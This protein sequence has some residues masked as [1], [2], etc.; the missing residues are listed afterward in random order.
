MIVSTKLTNNRSTKMQQ[1]FAAITLLFTCFS[2]F[3]D[4]ACGS[5]ISN[6][7][8][9]AQR[10]DNEWPL[11]PAHDRKTRFVQ[12]IAD[13]LVHTTQSRMHSR[14]FNWPRRAWKLLLVRDLSVNA[15]SIGDGRIYLTDGTFDFVKT[16]AEL[17]AI[18]AHE[19]AHQLIGH[20]CQDQGSYTEYRIGSLVQVLDNNK[21]MEADAL[22][23]E[24]LQK[25]KFPA[26]AMFDI[27]KRLPIARQN[28]SHKRVRIKA[29]EQQLQG[30]KRPPFSS[31]SEFIKI[32]SQVGS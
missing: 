17:A 22:A 7:R 21:E 15:Y 12:K 3:V 30:I 8:R 24:I 11:R 19:L 28:N 29:L 23:V 13:S 20:F 16:E 5:E 14:Y 10:I 27:V 2:P 1:L 4:A 32:K 18:I 9:V 25:A 31:S 26:Q 6:A